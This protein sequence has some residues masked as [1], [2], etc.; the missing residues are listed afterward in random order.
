MRKDDPG[1]LATRRDDWEIAKRP[2]VSDAVHFFEERR[3][4][5]GVGA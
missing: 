3:M 4:R 2:Q 5:A 1:L